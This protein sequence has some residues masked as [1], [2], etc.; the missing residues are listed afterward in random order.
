MTQSVAAV[1]VAAGRG[2]RLSSQHSDLPK[3]YRPLAGKRILTRT[4]EA[5]LHHPAI[6]RVVPVIG[7]QDG[8][9][10]AAVLNEIDPALLPKCAAPVKGGETRQVSVL[11]GLSALE[12]EAPGL[13]LIHDAAR[14]LVTSA[15]LDRVIAALADGAKAVLSAVPVVDTLKRSGGPDAPAAPLKTVDRTHLWA[16]QTPQGFAFDAILDAHLKARTSG[17]SDFTDDT[18]LM[19]W[20]SVPVQLI[21]GDAD[22]FKVTTA[23]DLPRAERILAMSQASNSPAPGRLPPLSS[24]CD[25]RVGTGYDVHAFEP[26]EAVILGGVTL[27]HHKR[28]KGHSD[29]DVVLHAI[30]DAILG[31]LGDGDIGSHFSPSDPQ[32][33]GASSDR[34]LV[35]AVGRVARRGGRVAHVDVTIVCEEPKIGPHREAL[36]AS[37]ADICKL[38]VSRVSV[39]A[40]T[41]E[42]LGFTGRGEGIAALATATV[43]LP[44]DDSEET[45]HA[46]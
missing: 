14:P 22:N 3:Q 23:A 30:T 11:H 17:L 18:A 36:R 6:S 37:I 43:R 29:A 26:G 19:E 20:A 24:L 4:L 41:S 32:W 2:T 27:Q 40:T 16:A 25:V 33:K 21:E 44:F 15:I 42:R 38:S 12:A 10:F 8:A 9:L 13:V 31:A 7:S 5:F 39:K 34:F 1:I 45:G 46:V 28:L 35:D